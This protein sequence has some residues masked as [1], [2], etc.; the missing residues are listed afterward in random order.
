VAHHRS[1]KKRNRQSINRTDRN[2][3]VLTTMRTFIKRVRAAVKSG[4]AAAAEVQLKAA[5]SQV[6]SGAQ[7]GVI[8]R[9]NASRMVSRLTQAVNKLTRKPS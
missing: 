7:K 8:H 9:R 2:R 4:D 1:A 5:I 6:D 3:H